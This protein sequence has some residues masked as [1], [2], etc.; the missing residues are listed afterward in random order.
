MA[1][2]LSYELII[3]RK[4]QKE[5]SGIPSSFRDDVDSDIL[6]LSKIQDLTVVKNSQTR[7]V[8]GSGS[9]ITESSIQ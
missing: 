8:T 4:A 9:A 5:A 6:A 7:K 3:E 1:Q 2:V